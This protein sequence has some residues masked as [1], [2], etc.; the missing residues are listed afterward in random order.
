MPTPSQLYWIFVFPQPHFSQQW[1]S[2]FSSAAYTPS[3]TVSEWTHC[4]FLHGFVFLSYV[5]YPGAGWPG[6]FHLFW[7]CFCYLILGFY[8]S[9]SRFWRKHYSSFHRPRDRFPSMPSG[10]F[11]FIIWFG[12]LWAVSSRFLDE[13]IRTS[14]GSWVVACCDWPLALIWTSQSNRCYG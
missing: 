2:P 5:R 11:H 7:P 13:P 10:V 3:Y 6:D 1:T 14:V 9:S 12:H 4:W 8:S